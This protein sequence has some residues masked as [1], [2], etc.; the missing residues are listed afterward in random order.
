MCNIM[1]WNDFLKNTY[2]GIGKVH[3]S[4]QSIVCRYE[5]SLIRDS[6]ILEILENDKITKE[7]YVN[8]EL[9]KAF[10]GVL[11]NLKRSDLKNRIRIY[12]KN[13]NLILETPKI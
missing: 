9:D 5:F 7:L 13:D 8:W 6:F 3:M 2:K 12:D 11:L 10:D 4:G 1:T